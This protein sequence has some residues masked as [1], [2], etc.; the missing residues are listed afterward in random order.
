MEKQYAKAIYRL[1]SARAL[2]ADTL[3][4]LLT[5]HLEHTGRLKLL[6]RIL[7]ELTRLEANAARTRDRI[8]IASEVDR[9]DALETA[10]SLGIIAEPTLVPELASG[11]RAY[12][13]GS[14]IDRSGKR[15]LLDLYRS[16]T[17]TR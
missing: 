16:I 15:A 11:W 10:R 5:K 12:G 9:A 7:K 3:S 6:P 17:A 13:K 8:E 1:M 2:D 14:L 4:R